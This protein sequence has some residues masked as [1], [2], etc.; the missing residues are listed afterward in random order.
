MRSRP[1]TAPL[2]LEDVLKGG[3]PGRG[4]CSCLPLDGDGPPPAGG[5]CGFRIGG[6][7][8][9]RPT[10]RMLPRRH[11]GDGN[12][13]S[14]SVCG[15]SDY[16]HC[17]SPD[18][19]PPLNPSPSPQLL[20]G[21]DSTFVST[22]L[23]NPPPIRRRGDRR[24]QVRGALHWASVG[25][26]PAPSLALSTTPAWPLRSHLGLLQPDPTLTWAPGKGAECLVLPHCV[27]LGKSLHFSEFP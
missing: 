25:V 18:T 1:R 11:P 6:A 15:R 14:S 9:R 24:R 13:K 4:Q 26:G 10:E 8:T 27:A 23:L 16:H 7:Q 3:N 20:E 19:A 2:G 21:G 17:P 5:D 12:Q 22:P